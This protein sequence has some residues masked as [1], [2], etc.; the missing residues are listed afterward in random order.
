MKTSLNRMGRIR[1]FPLLFQNGCSQ[2]S[3]FLPQARRF[4]GSGDENDC[5]PL[6]SRVYRSHCTTRPSKRS[7]P[8]L[9]PNQSNSY[10]STL[11][12]LCFESSVWRHEWYHRCPFPLTVKDGCATLYSPFMRIK[13]VWLA[14]NLP[15]TNKEFLD[16][17]FY[18]CWIV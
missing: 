15:D 6:S 1:L 18:W 16:F 3:R 2:S 11:N 13:G 12:Y 8:E 14:F 17:L 9:L 10:Q 4:V 7:Y 5:V